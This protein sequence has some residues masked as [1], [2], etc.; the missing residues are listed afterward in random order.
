VPH[1][2][3][4]SEA[5]RLRNVLGQGRWFGSLP[6]DLQQ[7]ILSGS[8]VRSFAR[9]EVIALE[10]A[11]ASALSAV[12][13]G[14]VKLVRQAR[15]GHESLLW[16]AE[17]GS[18]FGEYAVLTG[19]KILVTAIAKTP[20]R[21]LV[22]PKTELDRIV[23]DEPLHFRHFAM[24]A[25]GRISNYLKAYIHATSLHPEARLRG[26]LFVLSQMKIDELGARA[27]VELPYSQAEL[28]SL[29]GVT[30]QTVNQLLQT[31]VAK[32]LVEARFKHVRVLA[33]PEMLVDL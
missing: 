7:R 31:L 14:E 16:I 33:P 25:I 17:T 15:Q 32:G 22:L 5:G 29:I 2:D 18:W 13:D 20:T 11:P 1:D 26:Q 4:T 12:L 23:K 28:A 3:D 27:P 6:Q 10:G 24:L 9:G 21:L 30:R 8:R 19:E